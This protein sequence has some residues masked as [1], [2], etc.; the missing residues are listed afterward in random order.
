MSTEK[1]IC[2]YPPN[3]TGDT[4]EWARALGQWL[5]QEVCLILGK[6]NELE[7]RIED[8]EP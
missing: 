1:L 3:Y 8:L 6:L 5:Y 7:Q 2:A 4:Q